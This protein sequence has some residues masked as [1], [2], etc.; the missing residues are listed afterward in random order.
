MEISLAPAVVGDEILFQ[1]DLP[2]APTDSYDGSSFPS[3]REIAGLW[4]SDVR[5]TIKGPMAFHFWL[6]EN[7][8]LSII[9]NSNVTSTDIEYYR[10]GPY[11][12]EENRLISS[13]INNG[14]PALLRVRD[15]EMVLNID[16]TL[17]ILLRRE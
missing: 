8:W 1:T 7:G 3:L 11:V 15:G 14:R 6:T 4:V 10:S 13:V 2:A 16:Q 12:L 9:G 5:P 17:T